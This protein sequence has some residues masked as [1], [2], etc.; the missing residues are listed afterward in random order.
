MRLE[1]YKFSSNSLRKMDPK[2]GM[3]QFCACSFDF[4]IEFFAFWVYQMIR[5]SAMHNFFFLNTAAIIKWETLF[6][7]Y[8]R[9]TLNFCRVKCSWKWMKTGVTRILKLNWLSY[10][11]SKFKSSKK[12]QNHEILI[13]LLHLPTYRLLQN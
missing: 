3:W 2:Y 6:W 8:N 13:N 11:G 5:R 9:F 12:F 10:Y 7:V 1:I 4:N